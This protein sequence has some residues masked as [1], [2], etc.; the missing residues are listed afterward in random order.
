MKPR[1][2]EHLDWKELKRFPALQDFALRVG[3]TTLLEIPTSR[4]SARIFAKCE[5]ENPSGSVKDRVSFAMLYQL[6]LS[7]SEQ[8]LKEL[9]LLEYSGGTLAASLAQLCHALE[10]PL[11]MVL[12][13]FMPGS[14]IEN[15]R[16]LG[17]NIELVD[18]DKGFYAV[19]ERAF[20]LSRNHPGRR[21]LHQH[22]NG[23]NLWIHRNTTGKEILHQFRKMRPSRNSGIDAWIA[24][25]GTGGTLMGVYDALTE[26]YPAARLFAVTPSEMPYGTSAPPNGLP[27]FAG[28]GGFGFGRRQPFVAKREDNIFG[29]FHFSYPECL[30]EIK[31][32]AKR[33]GV[34]LGTSSAANLLAARK[35]AEK[36]GHDKNVVTI[37]PS[38]ASEEEWGLA[39]AA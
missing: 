10:L 3:G 25:I 19:M 35:V 38:F 8:E 29:H 37:F 27:K 31:A 17:A 14:T 11:T 16:N 15:L 18:K 33:T 28:S 22:E 7:L 20:E 32:F 24:S 9:E 4:S 13:S 34:R 30:N 39:H 2:T 23:A 12:G 21:F 36:L 26:A 1:Y 5:G 6:L